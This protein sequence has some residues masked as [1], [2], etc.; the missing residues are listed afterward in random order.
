MTTRGWPRRLVFVLAAFAALGLAFT[1]GIAVDKFKIFP[2]YQIQAGFYRATAW[3]GARQAPETIATNLVSLSKRVV[4][5]DPALEGWGGGLTRFGRDL[6]GVDSRG[7]FYL[8]SSDGGFRT[9]DITLDLNLSG[10]LDYMSRTPDAGQA[11]ARTFRVTDV[12]AHADGP[13]ATL[14][15]A[16]NFWVS[17]RSCVESRVARLNLPDGQAVARSTFRVESNAWQVIYR[18]VPCL[19]FLNAGPKMPGVGYGGVQS[20]GRLALDGAGHLILTLGD[21]M[22]DGVISP[23]M[24]AQNTAVSYGK[25]I[26]LDLETLRA[27]T[28]ASGLRNPQGLLLDDER[29]M[30]VS[31]QGPQG[32]DELNLITP[33]ANYGWPL[34]GYGVQY[35]TQAWPLSQ[36]QGRHDGYEMPIFAWT[37]SIAISNLVQIERVPQV[38][39]GDLLVGSLNGT[40]VRLRVRA[41]RVVMSELIA[42]GARIRDLEQMQ[43]GRIVLWTDAGYLI[44]LQPIEALTPRKLPL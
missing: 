14:Y 42:I 43:D 19:E 24:F 33:G 8:Y 31:D 26:S 2:Y 12:L 6:I 9:L 32:G 5:P 38:W 34:V 40:L 4:A 44:D 29:A 27:E 18:S 13:S 3:Y 36:D 7:T 28:R 1:Y 30:W 11:L 25:V 37:P 23:G 22:R 15:V 41:G 35:G 21:F 10:F 39:R 16:Y 17:A 20:G